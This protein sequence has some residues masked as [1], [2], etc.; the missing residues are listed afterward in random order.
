MTTRPI[1]WELCWLAA[2]EMMSMDN[3]IAQNAAWK[4]VKAAKVDGYNALRIQSVICSMSSIRTRTVKKMK[5]TAA[6]VGVSK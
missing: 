4:I 2:M 6:L 5:A 3:T 1:A